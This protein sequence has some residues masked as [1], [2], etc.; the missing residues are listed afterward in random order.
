[1]H[2]NVNDYI[3]ECMPV[4]KYYLV[5]NPLMIRFIWFLASYGRRVDAALASHSL[6]GRIKIWRRHDSNAGFRSFRTYSLR[7]LSPLLSCLSSST[8][9]LAPPLQQACVSTYIHIR[10]Y[11]M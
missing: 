5:Y 8:S 4:Y 7:T 10:R 1:M 11:D 9:K 2:I 3:K 6:S